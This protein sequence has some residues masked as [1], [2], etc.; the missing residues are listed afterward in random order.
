MGSLDEPFN[1][2]TLALGAGAT[3]I[4]RT[5]DKE[6][7]HMQEMIDCTLMPVAGAH[8]LENPP[9][10]CIQPRPYCVNI[11]MPSAGKSDKQFGTSSCC[12][13][14]RVQLFAPSR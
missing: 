12:W 6:S 13:R 8:A 1:P 5:I 10:R 14:M 11:A 9:E 7:K 4:A 3:F 2:L